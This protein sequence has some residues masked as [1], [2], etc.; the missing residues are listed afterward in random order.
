MRHFESND[1]NNYERDPENFL[2]EMPSYIKRSIDS[3]KSLESELSEIYHSGTRRAEK[4]AELIAQ[5]LNFNKGFRVYPELEYNSISE[6]ISHDEKWRYMAE[7]DLYLIVMHQPSMIN[8]FGSLETAGNGD[9]YKITPGG[10]G[11]FVKKIN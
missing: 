11:Y 3:I 6:V 10:Y 4:T 9:V 5:Y 8:T 1:M 2:K 7:K